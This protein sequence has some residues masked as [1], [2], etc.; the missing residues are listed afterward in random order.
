M[1]YRSLIV[2]LLLALV[3]TGCANRQDSLTFI[4]QPSAQPNASSANY[5]VRIGHD[6]GSAEIAAEL[7]QNG[8]CSQSDSLFLDSGA[9]SLHLLFTLDGFAAS[10]ADSALNLQIDADNSSGSLLTRFAL[11]DSIIGYSFQAYEDQEVIPVSPN[12]EIILAALAFDSGAGVRTVD[13]QQLLEEP[14]ALSSYSCLCIVRATFS[15]AQ[16]SD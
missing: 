5:E 4:Y 10:K 3:L 1:K 12:D 7:W 6:V 11:P 9:E 14:D 13:F 8:A 15:A 2:S 16:L